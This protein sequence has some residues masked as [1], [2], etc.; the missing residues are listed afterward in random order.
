MSLT[1]R[2]RGNPPPRRK[3]CAACIKAKRRCDMA[4]PACLRCSQRRVTCQYPN[5]RACDQNLVR[6]Q[7]DSMPGL[8]IEDA[9]C[10]SPG[11]MRQLEG[12][13]DNFNSVP[14]TIDATALG[15]T[16]GNLEA[17]E[18]PIDEDTLDLFQPSSTLAPPTVHVFDAIPEVIA[19]RLQWSID[20][21]C[22]AP[23]TMVLEN[24]TPWCH[25][26]L[27][28]DTMPHAHACCALY[29]AKNRVNS[30]IIFRSI[31]SHVSDLLCSPAPNTPIDCLAHTQ[32]LLLYQIIR[33]F[34]GDISARVSAERDLPAVESSGIAL[35]AHTK[36]DHY[37][38]STELPLFPI[39][40]T[41]TFWQDWI[42]NESI[43]RTLL[44]TF[45]FL[46]AYR[47]ISLQKGLKCD[48]KLGL[49]HSWTVSAHLWAARTPLEFAD[50]WKNKKH[51]VVTNACFNDLGGPLQDAMA[52]DIDT[53]GKIFITSLVGIDEAKG[54]FASRGGSL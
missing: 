52:D 10:L 44:F 16:F 12:G 14:A 28:K 42:L 43:R 6:P 37:P 47:I 54:W 7:L 48:G 53:Y 45:Y 3:S 19:N 46:Q 40:P 35:F 27:Y 11:T 41:K 8:L 1:A 20:A 38:P 32:A 18:L 39:A 29:L 24:Q 26:L 23:S 49:C 9:P 21:I 13:G 22:T 17:F 5:R 51:F 36:F 31:E 4:L 33:L 15:S 30:P 34:D 25:P 50:V 2:E